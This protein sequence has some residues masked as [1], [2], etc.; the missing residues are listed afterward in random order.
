VNLAPSLI[1]TRDLARL[2]G[3]HPDTIAEWAATVPGMRSARFRR[4]WWRIDALKRAG[5]LAVT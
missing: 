3:V 5:I 1:R 2:L 4:G